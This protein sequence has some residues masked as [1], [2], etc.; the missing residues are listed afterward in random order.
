MKHVVVLA[1][2]AAAVSLAGCSASVSAGGSDKVTTLQNAITDQLPKKMKD[3][4]QGDVTVSKVTCKPVSGSETNYDCVASISGT[5]ANGKKG[6]ADLQIAGT[7]K[8][9]GCH[10]ETK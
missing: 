1:L 9:K 6:S 4:G 8:D 7:C 10:W 2:V 3:T 5:D